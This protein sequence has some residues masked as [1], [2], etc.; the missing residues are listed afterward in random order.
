MNSS[1][2]FYTQV[3][4][5]FPLSVEYIYAYFSFSVMEEWRKWAKIQK[6]EGEKQDCRK[7]VFI[8]WMRNWKSAAEQT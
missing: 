2:Y 3:I 4:Y 6:T 5:L 7:D 8:L 1:T